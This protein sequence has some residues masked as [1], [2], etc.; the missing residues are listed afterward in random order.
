METSFFDLPYQDIKDIIKAADEIKD[1]FEIFVL[2]GIG[3]SSTWAKGASC[4]ALNAPF[5][6][7]YKEKRKGMPEDIFS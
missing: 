4:R 3:G 7:S 6:I 1:G 2:I 5:S